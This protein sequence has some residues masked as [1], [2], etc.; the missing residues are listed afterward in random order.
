LK[1]LEYIRESCKRM[2]EKTMR[3]AKEQAKKDVKWA[4]HHGRISN[5]QRGR[6]ENYLI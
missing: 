5:A 1:D 3:E 4:V 6:K 2:M